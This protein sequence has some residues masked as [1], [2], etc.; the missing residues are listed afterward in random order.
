MYNFSQFCGLT[1]QFFFPW[2]CQPER[3]KEGYKV[4]PGP[5]QV[6]GAGSWLGAQAGLW[7]GGSILFHLGFSAWLPAFPEH[8]E[9][10]LELFKA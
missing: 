9:K 5:A 8:E 10:L 2:C 6:A 7:M 1:G 4:P 3:Y